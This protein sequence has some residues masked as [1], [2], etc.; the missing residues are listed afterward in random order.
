MSLSLDVVVQQL[1]SFSLL[2]HD[3]VPR[4]WLES[5]HFKVFDVLLLFLV[6]LKNGLIFFLKLVD[7]IAK[8]RHFNFEVSSLVAFLVGEVIILIRLREE[9]W[10]L[11]SSIITFVFKF[12]IVKL[13][14]EYIS[15]ICRHGLHYPD[16][17]IT[18]D[19]L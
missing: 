7:Q 1:N 2:V 19:F 10:Y 13:L 14:G 5:T 4:V 6:E 15:D 16:A 11:F 12:N 8:F 3:F 17:K 9:L 18:W